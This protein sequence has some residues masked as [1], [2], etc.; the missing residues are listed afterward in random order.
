MR[1]VCSSQCTMEPLAG[2]RRFPTRRRRSSVVSIE[3][4]CPSHQPMPTAPVAQPPGGD[5]YGDG[6]LLTVTPDLIFELVDNGSLAAHF[7]LLHG[8]ETQ[9]GWRSFHTVE[10]EVE[11]GSTLFVVDMDSSGTPAPPTAEPSHGGG[12]SMPAFLMR[13]FQRRS[14]NQGS[15]VAPK[16]TQHIFT[17]QSHALDDWAPVSVLHLV[18]ALELCGLSLVGFHVMHQTHHSTHVVPV[19]PVNPLSGIAPRYTIIQ[20]HQTRI[21]ADEN[22]PAVVNWKVKYTVPVT[23]PGGQSDAVQIAWET[24]DPPTTTEPNEDL[25]HGARRRGLLP[26]ACRGAVAPPPVAAPEP[27]YIKVEWSA[28]TPICRVVLRLGILLREHVSASAL[29]QCMLNVPRPRGHA[30]LPR[31]GLGPFSK[32][33]FISLPHSV[34]NPSRAGCWPSAHAVPNGVSRP[35]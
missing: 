11:C 8:I 4:S 32:L 1:T 18:K 22:A 28:E 2:E 19:L 15:A 33:V 14:P 17:N 23:Y 12:T 24:M 35:R 3:P 6:A 34:P 7:R 9:P 26:V 27:P 5:A 31:L 16:C 10:T 20:R 13:A 30:D 21:G 29:R 25:V